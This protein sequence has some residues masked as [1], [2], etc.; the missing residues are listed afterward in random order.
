MFD[1]DELQAAARHFAIVGPPVSEADI[2]TIFP[3]SFPGKEDLAQFYLWRNGGSRTPQGCVIHCGNP[4]HKVARHHLDKMIV[5]GFMS[6]P[7]EPTD[8]MLPFKPISG[9]LTTMR[10]IYAQVPE[11]EKFLQQNIP[12]AFDHSGEDIC[13]NLSDGS[14]SYMD[15]TEYRKGSI[16][17][18]PSFRHFVLEYWVNAEHRLEDQ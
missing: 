12:F 2:D 10:K 8:R 1:E 17:V 16:Q 11:M 15:Y 14:V 5:E 3:G 6:V 13:V 4:K 9:H 18:A 7:L